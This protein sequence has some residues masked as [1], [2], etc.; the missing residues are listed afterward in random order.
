MP[1][2][3]PLTPLITTDLP[4][5]RPYM[6]PPGIGTY[7]CGLS[8]IIRGHRSVSIAM[9]SLYRHGLSSMA[10]K[11]HLCPQTNE[12][13]L[14]VDEYTGATRA[15]Y[16]HESPCERR[17]MTTGTRQ[18]WMDYAGVIVA[19]LLVGWSGISLSNQDIL[20]DEIL[21][22][23]LLGPLALLLAAYTVARRRRHPEGKLERGY[24]TAMRDFGTAMRDFGTVLV[25][26][27]ASALIGVS[28]LIDW[29][30]QGDPFFLWASALQLWASGALTAY[31][32]VRFVRWR[33][34]LPNATSGNDS[35]AV[36]SGD[37]GEAS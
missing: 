26:A 3:K 21:W 2:V 37:V 25:V 32:L 36:G 28:A 11:W 35:R 7:A 29:A 16:R 20:Q 31:G 8:W 10:V 6:R 22:V 30:S 9:T 1:C 23:W 15:A 13:N 24:G 27:A 17:A 14:G 33:A 19:A 34:N 4:R 18:R 12:A 5:Y